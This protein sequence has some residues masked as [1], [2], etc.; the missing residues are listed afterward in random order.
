MMI[1]IRW[2]KVP[3]LKHMKPAFFQGLQQGGWRRQ[4]FSFAA[5]RTGLPYSGP[6][7]R[8]QQ[9]VC[10]HDIANNEAAA[11]ASGQGEHGS[12]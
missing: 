12:T 11:A 9:G 4:R 7:R 1:C 5:D 8:P 3:Y 6:E 10:L 2:I